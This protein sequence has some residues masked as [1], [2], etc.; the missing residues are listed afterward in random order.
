MIDALILEG[1]TQR[2]VCRQYGI[3]E[4]RLSLLRKHP[5]FL[6][7]EK[8]LRDKARDENISK[9]YSLVPA[10]IKTLEDTLGVSYETANGMVVNNDVRTRVHSAKEILNRAGVKSDEEDQSKTIHINMYAPPY[11]EDRNEDGSIT[12]TIDQADGRK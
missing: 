5:L 9:L 2:E 11:I 12:V 10:A 8:Q 3:S 7:A 4:T 1:K 6:M